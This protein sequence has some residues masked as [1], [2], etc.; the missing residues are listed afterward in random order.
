M[1]GQSPMICPDVYIKGSNSQFRMHLS[2]FYVFYKIEI[3]PDF[4]K[5]KSNSAKYE[6]LPK[7]VKFRWPPY[8]CRIMLT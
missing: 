6:M 3:L 8:P 1:Q 4:E 5:F 7:L 2:K